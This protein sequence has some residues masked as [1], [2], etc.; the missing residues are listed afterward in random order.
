MKKIS[1]IFVALGLS[2]VFAKSEIKAD[3][4]PNQLSDVSHRIEC[5]GKTK[6]GLTIII[7]GETDIFYNLKDMVD[8]I[9]MRAGHADPSRISVEKFA[10]DSSHNA[11]DKAAHK[12]VFAFIRS[13]RNEIVLNYAKGSTANKLSVIDFN[14]DSA[15]ELTALP[16][17][18]KCVGT[19]VGSYD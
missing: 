11:K 12:N 17:S 4:K 15:P 16:Q 9:V 5:S 1:F 7:R 13:P 19:Q 3:R 2:T 6:N 10:Y 8:L 18:V 14:L